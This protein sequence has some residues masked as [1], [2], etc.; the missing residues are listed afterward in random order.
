QLRCRHRRPVLEALK[1][2]PA[3]PAAELAHLAGVGTTVIKAMA[4]GGLLEGVER[5][6]RRSFPQPDGGREGPALSAAQQAAADALKER[7]KARTFSATL[8]DGVPGAGKTEVYFEAI[9]AALATGRQ[10]LVLLPG[11][12]LTAQW[13]KRFEDRFGCTPAP[14]HSGLT[15]LERRETWRAI[16]Q[17]RIGVVV[18]A[19]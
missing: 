16:A 10:V 1:D 17:G 7:V 12:A 15:S 18:G 14:W 13:L 6:V 4:A 2:G 5:V 9:A 19:R 8:L 3:M 11:I